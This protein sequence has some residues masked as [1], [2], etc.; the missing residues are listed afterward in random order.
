MKRYIVLSV[1]DNPEYLYYLPLTISLWSRFGWWP[2][3]FSHGKDSKLTEFVFNELEGFIY[4]LNDHSQ[5]KSETVAQISRLYGACNTDGYIMTGDIDMIPLS[6]YWKPDMDKLTVWGR[7]LTDYHYPICYI[8]APS[9]IWKDIMNIGDEDYNDLIER[10]L[11][12]LPQAKSSDKVKRWVTDQ[13]LI[14]ERIN[15]SSYVPVRIDRGTGKNGYP[16]GRVDRSAWTL[17]HDQFIDCHMMRGIY[18]DKAAFDK[19]MELLT[20]VF[21]NDEWSW[22]VEYTEKF[23]KLIK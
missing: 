22:F 6:D 2:M 10:D 21:P 12:S 11:N 16:I 23:N 1:N 17:K 15:S 9:A 7:D 18:R 19:T 5:F 8:G 20:K 4:F 14:T 3:V 13:D